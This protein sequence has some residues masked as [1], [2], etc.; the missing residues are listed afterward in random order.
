MTAPLRFAFNADFAPYAWSDDG[1]PRGLVIERIA[2]ACSGWRID[3]IG[4]G[5]SALFP[6]LA[7]G[8]V[9][10]IAGTGVSAAR[11]ELAFSVPIAASGGAWF[12]PR[13]RAWPDD[14]ALAGAAGLGLRA[15]TPR[16]GPLHA[17][18]ARLFPALALIDAAGYRDALSAALDGRA[19]AAAL[20]VDVGWL[21]AERDFPDRFRKP[22]RCFI[23]IPL[24]L[25]M[26]RDRA[27]EVMPRFNEALANSA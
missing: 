5:Q 10:A 12:V 17:A 21:Q 14:D 16:I 2:R 9:D 15:A 22:T 27:A 1:K 26:R 19:D 24:A 8:A 23:D 20:N 18:I 4:L 25:A 6:A 7:G 3:W 11:G 13:D